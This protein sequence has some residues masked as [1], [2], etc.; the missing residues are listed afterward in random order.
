MSAAGHDAEAHHDA[1]DGG[2]RLRHELSSAVD[3]T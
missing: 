1:R 3:E 2:I